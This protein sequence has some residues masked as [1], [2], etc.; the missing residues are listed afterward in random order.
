[1]TN[2]VRAAKS[3]GLNLRNW[4]SKDEVVF[5]VYA[6]GDCYL[7]TVAVVDGRL[8]QPSAWYKKDAATFYALQAQF[9]K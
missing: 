8:A 6:A 4:S 9:V 7:G 5:A 3:C 2:L 1:M